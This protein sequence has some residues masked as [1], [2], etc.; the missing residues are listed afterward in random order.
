M[1]KYTVPVKIIFEGT[2]EVKADD[3]EEAKA[4]AQDVTA[5]IDNVFAEDD[6]V[7]DWN[8]DTHSSYTEIAD[9]NFDD[10]E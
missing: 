2:V 1:T 10:V 7:I 3:P 8:I 5:T 4:I 6:H 9:D